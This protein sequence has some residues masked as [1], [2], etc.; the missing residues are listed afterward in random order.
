MLDISSGDALVRSESDVRRYVESVLAENPSKAGPEGSYAETISKVA[1]SNF[2]V[3][4]S[5]LYDLKVGRLSTPLSMPE[6]VG[7]RFA[8]IS[9]ELRH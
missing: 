7:H 9:A 3:A 2:L 8:R 1:G 4:A 6:S 5:H